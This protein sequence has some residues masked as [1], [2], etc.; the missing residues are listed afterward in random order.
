MKDWT[1]TTPDLGGYGTSFEDEKDVIIVSAHPKKKQRRFS[2][3]EK[4]EMCLF[5]SLTANR[6]HLIP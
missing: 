3:K 6:M 1:I 5:A 2:D 4:N